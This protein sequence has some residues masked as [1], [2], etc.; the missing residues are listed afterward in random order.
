[1]AAST[2]LNFAGCAMGG[3]HHEA[4]DTAARALLPLSGSQAA[5][6][7]G[8]AERAD[9]LLA[10]LLNGM[11]SAVYSFDDTHAQA[12]VH[13]GGPVACAL[14]ALAEMRRISGA[15]FLLAFAIGAEVV[16]RISKSVSVAPAQNE[17]GWIQTGIAA[18]MGAAVATGKLLG[19]DERRIAAAMGIAACQ[20]GGMRSLSRSM[21]FSFMA[22]QAAQAGLRAALMAQQGFTAPADV[23]EAPDGFLRL[24]SRQSHAAYAAEGL[25]HEFELLRN[26]FKPYPCGVVIHPVIDACLELAGR[27]ADVARI[28]SIVLTMAPDSI[29]L[30]DVPAPRT[31][32]EGQSSVQHWAAAA[33]VNGQAGLAQGRSDKLGDPLIAGL[34]ARVRLQENPGLERDA[35]VVEITLASAE[36]LRAQ[37]THCRGSAARPMTVDDLIVK[38]RA[39]CA[40]LLDGEQTD[41]LA[42]LCLAAGELDDVSAISRAAAGKPRKV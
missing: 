42:A 39:Q 12:V 35:A 29:R 31:V 27:N 38:F 16:C 18:G 10:A 36:V 14:L 2:L 22:G 13:P 25:G 23:L 7:M 24:Y 40:D 37:V 41:N 26:T 11:S 33:L 17:N 9:P 1:M 19:L 6:V 8:R 20:A 3:A 34:R 30:V 32:Q 5:T 15:D 21:C 28:E 4:V